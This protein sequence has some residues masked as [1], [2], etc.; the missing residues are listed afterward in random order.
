M[1]AGT[2][3]VMEE[4]YD[5]KYYFAPMEGITGYVYRNAHHR[6]FPGADQYFTPFLSPAQNHKLSSREKNDILPG[7]NA[8]ISLVPQILTNK[9]E[10]FIWAAKEL[11]S[12]GYREVNLNLGCPS[13]TV[14]A[15]NK[16]AGFLS[17]PNELD[18][19]LE[20]VFSGLET[21]AVQVSVKTRTGMES[22]D[23]FEEL[24]K[25]YNRY[26]LK[27]LIIHP[28]VRSDFYAN[29]PEREVFCRGVRGSNNPVCYNG[30]IFTK[31]ESARF[32][33]D[34]PEDEFPMLK[35]IMLGRGAVA[36]PWLFA[37]VKGIKERSKPDKA[38]LRAFHDQIFYGY[39]E[40]MSGDRNTLFKMKEL[41]FYMA[42][43]FDDGGE[44]KKEKY[45]KKIKKAQNAGA[46]LDAVGA[47]FEEFN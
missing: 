9:A 19:F 43:L 18:C 20:Q 41:W 24:L 5:M 12:Y 6:F 25:I 30:D 47:L 42:G 22:H 44:G 2:V 14:T 31:E 32:R 36:N 45:I 46:Y 37:E 15:K 13:A 33:S 27:E 29:K 4:K 39:Q 7:H 1:V 21:E 23:E 40:I 11:S 26:P 3:Q 16:G 28:R 8:G 34:F 35:S 17:V 38:T 10:D